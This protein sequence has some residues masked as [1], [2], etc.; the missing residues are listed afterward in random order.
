MNSNIYMSVYRRRSRS[1]SISKNS[2]NSINRS[3]IYNTI[4]LDELKKKLDGDSLD[5]LTEYGIK[6]IKSENKNNKNNKNSNHIN[7][8][9]NTKD[10]KDIYF[11]NLGKRLLNRI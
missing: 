10:L 8:I 9:K 7:N 2:K 6:Y 11:A 4:Y 5:K 3:K 1:D